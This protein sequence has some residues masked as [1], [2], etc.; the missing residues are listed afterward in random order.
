MYNRD[1]RGKDNL[2]AP[3]QVRRV[4]SGSGI[5]IESEIDSDFVVFCPFHNNYRTPAGEV[6]KDKGTFFCF[7]CQTVRTLVEFVMFTTK[8]TYFEAV[9]FIDSLAVETDI[10]NMV[11]ELLVETP[12]FIP[13]DELMIRRL[14]SQALESPRAVR[15][16]EGRRISKESMEKF[17]LGYSENQDM[18]TIPVSNPTGDMFVGFVAR[19]V[20]G[21]DFKNTPKLPK[22]KILFNLHRARKYDTV[23]VVESSFDAIRLDQNGVPAVAT[24]GANVSKTQTDLLTKYFNNVIVVGDNDDAGK[25][26]QKKILERLAHRATLISI[27]SRFKD[28]GDMTDSDIQELTTRVEDPILSLFK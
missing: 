7:S 11:D 19:S 6:S 23:Y 14:H 3:E 22:G 1:R 21:K 16:Y 27:P 8:K 18:V 25:E 26:M 20:E 9:R 4:I 2:Y 24:L 12:E 5:R 13:F 28:V 17:L 10:S 15:Y